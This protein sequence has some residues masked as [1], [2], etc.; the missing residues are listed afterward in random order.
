MFGTFQPEEEHP[1]YGI[2]TPIQTWDAVTSHVR[3]FQNLIRDWKIVHEWKYKLQLLFMK[4]GWLPEKYGGYRAP[5]E[6]FPETYVKFETKLNAQ[7]NWYMLV[8]FLLILAG[9][10]FFLFGLSAMAK[11]DQLLFTLAISFSIMSVGWLF[12]GRNS[13]KWIEVARLFAVAIVVFAFFRN[14][15]FKIPMAISILT[16]VMFSLIWLFRFYSSTATHE[17]QTNFT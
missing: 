14:A 4:P 8:H 5:K 15:S 6:V 10:T 13:A 11:T 1:V 2:T 9:T 3:P 12:E 7:M 16:V 17:R